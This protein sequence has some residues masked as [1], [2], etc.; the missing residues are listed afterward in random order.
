MT[1]L[2]FDIQ[3]F[4]VHDG[5]GIRTTVFLKGCPLR[6]RWCHN[7]EGLLGI[8]Q[9]Q[10]F[11]EKCIG[12]RRCG[13]ERDARAAEKCPTEALKP[14]GRHYSPEELLP[15]LTADRDFYGAKGGVTFS[16]GECMLQADFL[17]EVLTLL[18]REGI[19]TAIDTCGAV[20]WEQFEK[21]LELCR[22]YLYDVKCADPELHRRFTGQDHR[23][24][25]E[26][27]DRLSRRGAQLLIRVPVIPGFN[28]DSRELEAVASL[29]QGLEGVREVT[30]IPYHTLG[31]SKY[32]TLGLEPPYTTDRTV[33]ESR[34]DAFRD[35]F[36]SKGIPVRR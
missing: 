20:P 14:V 27:L 34:L 7:P 10:F 11:E 30:L 21:T 23:L 24:I 9:I 1:G 22:M 8:P 32:R 13:G 15:L 17:R 29:L 5:P 12:C 26:N 31:R 35:I 16:G 3:R 6:C 33:S 19:H 25:L 18:R 36:R 2:I 28:D 4:S